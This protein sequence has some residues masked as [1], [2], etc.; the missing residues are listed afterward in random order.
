[1]IFYFLGRSLLR[2]SDRKLRKTITLGLHLMV[3][4]HFRPLPLHGRTPAAAS[5]A[6]LVG[7]SRHDGLAHPSSGHLPSSPPIIP[8]SRP[9]RLPPASS[10]PPL[11]SPSR[12]PRR[13]TARALRRGAPIRHRLPRS[14]PRYLRFDCRLARCGTPTSVRVG[15]G[16]SSR[17]SSCRRRLHP[18]R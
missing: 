17:P 1:M 11:L 12:T 9:G 10:L 3:Y 16:T 6:D 15:V 14:S 8:P 7:V 4:R 2:H 13:Q 5:G 18:F